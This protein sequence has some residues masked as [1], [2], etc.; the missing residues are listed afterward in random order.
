M[1]QK[2]K[3]NFSTTPYRFTLYITAGELE[4]LQGAMDEEERLDLIQTAKDFTNKENAELA[5]RTDD[6]WHTALK[7]ISKPYG[8]YEWDR[9]KQ[10]AWTQE[11]IARHKAQLPY[12]WQDF[13][14]E[15]VEFALPAVEISCFR[16][17]GK[18]THVN[19]SIDG[20]GIT[21]DEWAEWDW[22]ERENYRN[23]VYDVP[24]YE[25][26][27]ECKTKEVVDACYLSEPQK[28]LLTLLAKK[29]REDANYARECEMERRMGA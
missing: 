2:S 15:E 18:G 13:D 4:H 19:P 6:E 17:R 24:C 11:E 28:Y 21:S 20:N 27:G 7:Y 5:A 3:Q 23:G 16:C 10:E 1:S 26:G 25:C 9:A 8:W 14:L 22:E 29:W 12:P